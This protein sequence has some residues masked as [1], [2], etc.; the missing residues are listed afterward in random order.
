MNT[1]NLTEKQI[2]ALAI[3]EKHGGS[4]SFAKK[5]GFKG[6]HG[7][8]RVNNWKTRGIPWEVRFNFPQFFS[9]SKN[10]TVAS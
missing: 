10:S 1:T 7:T 3:I 6:N 8:I 5:L 9:T 2:E 4:A